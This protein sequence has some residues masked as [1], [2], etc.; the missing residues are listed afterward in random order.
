MEIGPLYGYFPNGSKTHILVMLHH[1]EA[2]EVVFK[3]IGIVILTEGEFY[4][5]R[6]I[7]A[8]SFCINTS[9]EKW[10]VG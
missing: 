10:N 7:G 6:A 3:G 5:S 1:A 2:A 8:S 9:Q 4:L